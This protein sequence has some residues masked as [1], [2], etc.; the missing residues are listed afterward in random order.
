[1]H[2]SQTFSR[3][4]NALSLSRELEPLAKAMGPSYYRFGGT[5][6]DWLKFVENG[7]T[8]REKLPYNVTNITMSGLY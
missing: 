4:Y 6:A 1:V 7:T 5:N 2:G 3:F 8:Y